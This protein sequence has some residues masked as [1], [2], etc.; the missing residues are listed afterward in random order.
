MSSWSVLTLDL[1]IPAKRMENEVQFPTSL[2]MDNGADER[3]WV[4]D[5][6]CY[7]LSNGRYQNLRFDKFLKKMHSPR[8]T[9]VKTA[10]VAEVE[11]TGDSAEIDIYKPKQRNSKTRIDAYE[12]VDTVT[13]KR[14]PEKERETLK[15]VVEKS[16]GV[17]PVI[18]PQ[19]TMTPPD[20]VVLKS[21]VENN[22]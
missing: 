20:M 3:G 15:N 18:E 22:G 5:T 19:E 12:V 2:L 17:R 9:G 13:G 6:V 11:N 16:W 4:S 14:W 10:A 8:F 21:E 1:E 7:T